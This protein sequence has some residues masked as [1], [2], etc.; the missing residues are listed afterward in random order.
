VSVYEVKN[1]KPGAIGVNGGG[2]GG[3]YNNMRVHSGTSSADWTDEV[4][5]GNDARDFPHEAGHLMGLENES[6]DPHNLMYSL[7]TNR[8]P[9][10]ALPRRYSRYLDEALKHTSD[11]FIKLVKG[12]GCNE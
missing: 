9:L 10:A 1:P 4:W 12:C 8:S 2:P 6:Q 3:D 11:G 5:A 7:E